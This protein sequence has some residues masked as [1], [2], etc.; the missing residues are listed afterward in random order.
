MTI[1]T[2]ITAAA[3]VVGVLLGDIFFGRTDIDIFYHKVL[4][5]TRGGGF[6]PLFGQYP[7]ILCDGNVSLPM[8]EEGEISEQFQAYSKDDIQHTKQGDI[9]VCVKVEHEVLRLL[10]LWSELSVTFGRCRKRHPSFP[11]KVFGDTLC[12]RGD[13]RCL[14]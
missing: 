13:R 2:G 10:G 3:L 5:S 12:H 4:C 7:K 6:D 9:F 11:G 8:V 1:N 14:T